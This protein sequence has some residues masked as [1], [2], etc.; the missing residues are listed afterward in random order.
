MKITLTKFRW[1]PSLLVW[2]LLSAPETQAAAP[3]PLRAGPITMIF[4]PASAFL[5]YVKVGPHEVL[6]GLRLGQHP[7]SALDRL[8]AEVRSLRLPVSVWL[9]LESNPT[10]YRLARTRLTA[11]GGKAL[12]GAEHEDIKFTQL[13][14]FRPAPGMREVVAD[15]VTPQ[16]HAFYNHSIMQTLPIQA[17]TVRS[18]RQ[19]IAASPLM[20]TPI[21]LRPQSLAQSPL[22]AE[23]PSSVEAREP[24]LFASAWTLGSIKYLAEAGVQ[25]ITCYE[26]VGWKGIM[27]S[28]AGSALSDK[29]RSKP[30]AVLPIYDVLRD[31]G[32]F[33]GGSMQ[34][35]ESSDTLAVAGLALHQGER[36]RLL[37]ANLT[38]HPQTAEL[39]GLGPNLTVK[40]LPLSEG[41]LSGQRGICGDGS[42]AVPTCLQHRPDRPRHVIEHSQ[43]L[44]APATAILPRLT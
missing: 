32:E 30:G 35:I 13:N 19:F 33:A 27:E 31:I 34:R 1:I 3:I 26:T 23:L 41:S 40:T 8:V 9:V 18:A 43:M 37:V 4:E 10:T 44:C 17:D 29:F 36:L 15:G 2:G 24:T 38:A 22:P 25:S 5:R 39:R 11:L 42:A 28:A 6:R 21:T 7:D 20:I 14:R 16:I 12:V